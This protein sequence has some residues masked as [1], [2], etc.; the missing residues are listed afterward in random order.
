MTRREIEAAL[1]RVSAPDPPSDLL[2]RCLAAVPTAT[3]WPGFRRRL[4]WAMLASVA[5][6]LL[7]LTLA[8]AASLLALVL[9]RPLAPEEVCRRAVAALE[10]QDAAALVALA[11]PEELRTLSI[12]PATVRALLGET[13][14]SDG[15]YAGPHRWIESN[16]AASAQT[17]RYDVVDAG[18]SASGA[19]LSIL[20]VCVVAERPH[21]WRLNLSAVLFYACYYR[22]GNDVGQARDRWHTLRHKY[23]IR[24][25][26]QPGDG[27]YTFWKRPGQGGPGRP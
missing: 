5:P 8:A 9:S 17:R 23:G 6:L 1:R 2:E 4:V 12:T 19:A 10:R 20:P 18:A 14:W 7:G 16:E 11:D 27:S 22:A 13:L 24:G 26:R 15:G 3:Q 21:Q 25:I